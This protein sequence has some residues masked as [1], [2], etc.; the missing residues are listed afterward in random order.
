[1][2]RLRACQASEERAPRAI[3]SKCPA[4]RSRSR[5]NPLVARYRAAARGETPGVLLLDGAHLVAEALAAGVA[6]RHVAVTT[7]ALKI[8]EIG[9]L[10]DT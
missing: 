5:Q 1:M 2:L 8:T 9:S 7:D 4:K 6:I 10:V 3:Q